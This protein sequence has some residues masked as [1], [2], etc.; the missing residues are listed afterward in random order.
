MRRFFAL[1][2][3]IKDVLIANDLIRKMSINEPLSKNVLEYLIKSSK[4]IDQNSD[5]TEVYKIFNE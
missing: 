5:H 4:I 3:M 2:L 1:D